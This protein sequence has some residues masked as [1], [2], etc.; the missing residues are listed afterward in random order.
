MSNIN[1]V[2]KINR[3][4]ERHKKRKVVSL[5]G[6]WKFKID[7]E[8]KGFEEKWFNGLP[9]D[10]REIVVPSCW[11]NELDLYHYEGTAW[12]QTEFETDADNINLVFHGFTGQIEIY[13]DGDKVGSQYGGFSGYNCPVKGIKAG[14]HMLVVAVDNTHDDLNTIPLARVDWFH[15][16]GL[17]R[18]VELMEL[19]DAWIK[20]YKIDYSLDDQM[21]NAILNFNL[22]FEGLSRKPVKE[23]L[24]VFINDKKICSKQVKIKGVTNLE[25]KGQSLNNIKLWDTGNPNLY[26]VR[27]E[28]GN[29]DIIERIGFRKIEVKDKSLLL[30]N[31]KVDIKG[32]NRHEDHPDWGFALPFKLMKKDID[33]IKDFGCNT[34]RGSHYPNAQIF[35]DYCDEQGILFWEEIPMWG[36]PEKALKSPLILERGLDMHEKMVNRDYHHP[37]IIIWGLHNEIDTRTQAA[38]DLSKAF[39]NKIKEIDNTRPLTYATMHPLKDICYELVDIVSVNKYFGWYEKMEGWVPFLQDLK[40]KLKNEG[41]EDMPVIMSEFGAGAIY[42]ESTFEGPKWTENYQKD[43]LEYTLKLFD[44]DPDIIGTYIWQYCDIRTA[45]EMEMGRPRSFNNKGLVN[46]YRNPKL[47]YWKVKEIYTNN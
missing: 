19:Y 46:E 34:I 37:S 47:A 24:D 36:Y 3:L 44:E 21:K 35:L 20:D 1:E 27:F 38:Y 26:N 30:N 10:N 42:G 7:P 14:E 9:E 16:G 43:Y 41:L 32:V 39:V 29:D 6:I 31:K 15:Y 22:T 28:L 45:R 17:F 33:I 8:D 11:N 12:Y 25:I 2:K 18:S 13:L 4:F 5:D 40:N 23:K